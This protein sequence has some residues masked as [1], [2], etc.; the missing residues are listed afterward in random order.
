M[1]AGVTSAFWDNLVVFRSNSLNFLLFASHISKWTFKLHRFFFVSDLKMLLA[2]HKSLL[3]HFSTVWPQTVHLPTLGCC[4]LPDWSFY[5][6]LMK[7]FVCGQYFLLLLVACCQHFLPLRAG[8]H[9][10][11]WSKKR[12]IF[13]CQNALEKRLQSQITFSGPQGKVLA[14]L[15]AKVNKCGQESCAPNFQ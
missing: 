1:E 13:L 3:A 9:T 10:V 4:F 12:L 11:V 2:F 5:I 7:W 6:V 15:N 8:A 14:L